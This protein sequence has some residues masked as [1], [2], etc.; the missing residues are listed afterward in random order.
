MICV[1]YVDDTIIGSLH[2]AD[3]N[4][5][6]ESLGILD[7]TRKHIF[8]LRN[9]G[10]V[11]DFL[12][13]HIQQVDKFKFQLTQVGLIEKILRSMNMEDCNGCDTP[14]TTDPLHA[15]LHGQGFKED[16]K[17]DS[18]IGMM[19]YLAN[20]TRPDIAY[21]V[22][23]AARFT[24]QPRHSHAVGVKRI[25]RYLQRTRNEGMWFCPQT[26]LRVDCYVDA[27][28]AGSFSVANKQD[29]VCAKSRTGYVIM[30]RGA[31]L[32]WASK[33]QTQIA[34]STMEAEYIALSQAMR[35]L[36]PIREVLKEVMTIVFEVPKTISYV[37]HSK[38]VYDND[39]VEKYNI[40]QSTVF[41]D[42]DACLKFA[43][44]PRLTPRTKHIGIPYHWFREQVESLQIQLER[45]DT[46]NQL[47]DQF[48]KGLP[49][50]LFR[51][52]RKRL[53]GW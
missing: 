30:Y 45:V 34:L 33:M 39:E 21:A 11:N 31:P 53:V 6:I 1:V 44:M 41:E 38:S 50:S 22:H 19:M 52:A 20:N 24:H 3:I 29:P 48:T 26:D 12:G 47:A 36:I 9:E 28:F 7:S 5:E 25:A 16:W 32:L 51:E 23:Q 13:I 37:T 2:I 49:T 42:N 8:T 43:R 46:K 14:A 17:Y 27:D 4:R 15:D 10:A 18:V 35:D 40:L